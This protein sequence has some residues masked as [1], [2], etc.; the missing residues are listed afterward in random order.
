[1][2]VHAEK[3]GY[4][5]ITL[6]ED[7]WPIAKTITLAIMAEIE[8]DPE[9][10]LKDAQEIDDKYWEDFLNTADEKRFFII[11][12]YNKPVAEGSIHFYDLRA[13]HLSGAHVLEENRGN[14]LINLL[15]KGRMQYLHDE[16]YHK[17]AMQIA[18]DNKAALQAAKRGGFKEIKKYSTPEFLYLEQTLSYKKPPDLNLG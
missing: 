12:E 15:H 11:N 2:K 5:C 4:K 3:D 7:E 10:T 8:E 16:G 1:M 17:A 6:A 9:F 14:Q 13:P 18:I